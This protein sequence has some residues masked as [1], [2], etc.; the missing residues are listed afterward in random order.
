ME[1]RKTSATQRRAKDVGHDPLM[2][3]TETTTKPRPSDDHETGLLFC[4]R[5]GGPWA[6][7]GREVTC[8]HCGFHWCPSCG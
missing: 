7:A 4:P 1:E 2:C 6:S 5:C 3:T 8:R